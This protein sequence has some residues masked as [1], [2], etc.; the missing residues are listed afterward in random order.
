GGPSREELQLTKKE[1]LRLKKPIERAIVKAQL[2]FENEVK[3]TLTG[4]RS[5]RIYFSGRSRGGRRDSQGKFVK[6]GAA[7]RGANGRFIRAG[8]RQASAPG[9]PPALVTGSFRRSI[10]HGPVE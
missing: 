9:E 1:L 8:A 7:N 3:K 4:K 2:R 6:K 5:G 10:T